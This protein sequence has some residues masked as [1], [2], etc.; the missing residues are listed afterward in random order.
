MKN[1]TKDSPP[2]VPNQSNNNSSSSNNNNNN[3]KTKPKTYP[4]PRQPRVSFPPLEGYYGL[5]LVV[6]VLESSEYI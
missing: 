5:A 1:V 6:S 4:V 3:N 2:K